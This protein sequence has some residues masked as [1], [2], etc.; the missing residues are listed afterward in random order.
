MIVCDTNV[1]I[2]ALLFPGGT[3]DR[4]FQRILAGRLQH[5]TSPDILTELAGVLERKFFHLAD[6]VPAVV[7]L[8]RDAS[9]M[10]YPAL[11]LQVIRDDPTDNRVLECALAAQAQFLVTGDRKHLLPLKTYEGIQIVSPR[12]FLALLVR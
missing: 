11:R 3:P 10:V 4:V 12:E 6:E 2:S 8:V 7:Q 9:Q 5:A 1:L